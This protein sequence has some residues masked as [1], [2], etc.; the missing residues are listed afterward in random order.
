MSWEIILSVQYAFRVYL[1]ST[2]N[3]GFN[4]DISKK[5]KIS[6]LTINPKNQHYNRGDLV[7]QLKYKFPC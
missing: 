6:K 2:I 3:S 4:N 1:V 5:F 7:D